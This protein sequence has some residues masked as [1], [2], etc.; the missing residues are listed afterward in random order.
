[1]LPFVLLASR[2]DD[3]AADAEYRAFCA[4]GGLDPAELQ[5][6]RM[7]SGPMPSID[8]DAVSGVIVGGGPFN[9]SDPDDAKSSVQRRVEREMSALLDEVV[10]R[11]IPFL[12]AC[13]G[14]GTLGVHQGGTVDRRFGEPV[15]AVTVTLTDAGRDDPIFGALPARFD[16]FVGHKEACSVA[17]AGSVVLATGDGCPVQAFRV[18]TNLYATQ[19]HPELTLDTLVER[20]RLYRHEG[21]FAPEEM[22][23]VIDAARAGAP[24]TAPAAVLR[25]FVERYAREERAVRTIDRG[26]S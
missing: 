23:A 3:A 26:S 14:I 5:R 11:D 12:G 7:E 17:P 6:V 24:V 19:F 1:M 22:D 21:Y 18:R 4:L 25:R 10:T 13:Y 16:A 9:A 2:A 15:G 20:V 8:L